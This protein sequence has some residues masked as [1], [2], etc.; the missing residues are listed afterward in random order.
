MPA[1]AKDWPDHRMNAYVTENASVEK[2]IDATTG[3]PSSWNV[4]VRTATELPNS[5]RRLHV[6][7]LLS[8]EDMV[9]FVQRSGNQ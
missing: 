5:V 8:V 7:F 2:A 3:A 9:N 6:S 1:F 4:F